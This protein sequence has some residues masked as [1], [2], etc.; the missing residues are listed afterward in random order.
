MG[1]DLEGGIAVG[2][3]CFID[4]VFLIRTINTS[5]E[6]DKLAE[7]SEDASTRRDL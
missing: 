7:K 2:Q 1:D 3:S 5:E 4:L 6:K